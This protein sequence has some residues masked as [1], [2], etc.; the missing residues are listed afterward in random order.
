MP[1]DYI[2]FIVQILRSALSESGP[3]SRM[4]ALRINLFLLGDLFDSNTTL[5]VI[6]TIWLRSFLVLLI[7]CFV[8]QLMRD[9]PNNIIRRFSALYKSFH[10]ISK[11][12]NSA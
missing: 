3:N 2:Y 9:Y 7:G 5:G 8:L 1:C 12:D 11:S 6:M 4:I 10:M